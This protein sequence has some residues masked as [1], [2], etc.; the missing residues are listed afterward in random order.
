VS[1]EQRLSEVITDHRKLITELRREIGDNSTQAI[2]MRYLAIEL[3]Q[4]ASHDAA[5]HARRRG[6]DEC[7]TC[8]LDDLLRKI[9]E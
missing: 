1:S 8:G 2:W 9:Y 4:Y 6:R 3:V 7:C 5:C